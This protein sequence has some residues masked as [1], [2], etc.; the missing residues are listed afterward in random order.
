VEPCVKEGEELLKGVSWSCQAIECIGTNY[1]RETDL[2]VCV[3]PKIIRLVESYVEEFQSQCRD[4]DCKERLAVE[5][6]HGKVV[7]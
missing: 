4:N 3:D 5:L 7:T 1:P 2:L 6:N